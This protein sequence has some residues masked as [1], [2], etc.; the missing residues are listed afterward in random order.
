M[1]D[2]IGLATATEAAAEDQFVHFAFIRRQAGG[3]EC[4]GECGFSVLRSAPDLAFV[5]RVERRRIQRLHSGV[6]LVGII[7]NRFDF[8]CGARDG[9]F[10]I[11]ILIADEGRL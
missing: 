4:R 6:V 3:F 5:R 8:L 10:G 7:V 2:I 11:A 1:A 9:S